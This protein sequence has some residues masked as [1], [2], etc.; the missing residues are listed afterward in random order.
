MMSI[1]Q[2][3]QEALSLP[4]DLRLQLV[5]TL[6][7]SFEDVIDDTIQSEWLS[8]A[9]RRRDEIRTGSIQPIAGDEALAQVRELLG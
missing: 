9:Q 7:A 3:T 1:D 8:E 4:N 2:L 6:L 5:E